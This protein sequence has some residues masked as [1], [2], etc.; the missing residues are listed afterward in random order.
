M[1][2]KNGLFSK[3]GSMPAEGLKFSE[4]ETSAAFVLGSR[5]SM[6]YQGTMVSYHLGQRISMRYNLNVG[7]IS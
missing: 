5:N 3:G 6:L 1:A 7:V 2:K 4:S